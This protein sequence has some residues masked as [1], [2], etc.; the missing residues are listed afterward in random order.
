MAGDLQQG[1]VWIFGD[2]I[3][4]DILA[5][6]KYMKG[7]LEEIAAHCMEAIDPSFATSVKVGDVIVA[8]KN[9]GI[10]SSREQ[11]AEALRHLGVSAV[12]A[13]SFGGIF[14][15]NALNLG[16]PVFISGDA[17]SFTQGEGV[18]LDVDAATLASC[19]QDLKITCEP[20]PG[21][22]LEMLH[23]GGLVPHL[24][25]KFRAQT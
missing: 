11:A 21:F 10:G 8:G 22:L 20:L 24:K 9:F 16:L 5:P 18:S 6:G 23:D 3:D 19:D 15:R 17:E 2:D 7:G 12:I 1:R 13:K 4:T 14:Y 25:S